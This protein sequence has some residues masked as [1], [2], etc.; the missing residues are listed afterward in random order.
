MYLGNFISK[1]NVANMKQ[2]PLTIENRWDIL[3]RWMV[4]R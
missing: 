2:K 4:R 3:Y 1:I